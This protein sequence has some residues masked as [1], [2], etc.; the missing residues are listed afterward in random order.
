[1]GAGVDVEA[2]AYDAASLDQ[3]R[4]DG[5]FLPAGRA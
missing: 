3:R 2:R 4:L 5:H 1:M